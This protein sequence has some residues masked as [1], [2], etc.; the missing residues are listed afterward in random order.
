MEAFLPLTALIVPCVPLVFCQIRAAPSSSPTWQRQAARQCGGWSVAARLAD[1]DSNSCSIYIA[2]PE[3]PPP[4]SFDGRA[5]H[6]L[7]CAQISTSVAHKAV[8]PGLC[9]SVGSMLHRRLPLF[10]SE[11]RPLFDARV[12]PQ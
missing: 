4:H 2:R 7:P 12:P 10:S 1:S 11:I 3:G 5:V 9:S 6:S 8:M